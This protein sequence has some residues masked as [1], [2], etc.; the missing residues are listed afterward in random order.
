MKI[1]VIGGNGHVGSFLVPQLLKNGHEVWIGGR[2]GKPIPE[3]SASY[4]AKSVVCTTNDEESLKAMAK[5]GF[6]V[7]MD[8]PGTAYKA[9]MALRDHTRHFIACG[10]QWMF[11]ESTRVPVPEIFSTRCFSDGYARRF[12]EIREMIADSGTH[13]AVFTAIMPPNICG[14]HKI[15]LDTLG[16]RDVEVHRANKRG[17]VVYL[18]DGPQC[19]ISPCDADDIATLFRL[20][21]EHRSAAAGQIFNVGSA[22]GLTASEFVRAYGYIHNVEI[23]IEYVSWQKYR[24]EISPSQGAWWHFYSHMCPDI[25]KARKLLGYE[26]KYTP[27]QTMERAIGWMRDQGML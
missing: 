14:P 8:F 10:S 22:Y 9:Y 2:Y 25:S 20:A 5:E 21:A 13:Q 15:P 1:L 4:G 7:V 26:P 16:G 23:P 18:P 27:E 24:D 17:E 3:G 12:D 6:D 11:G 19:L